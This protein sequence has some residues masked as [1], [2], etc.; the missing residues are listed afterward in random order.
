MRWNLL[1]DVRHNVIQSK[2]CVL[3]LHNGDYWV[4]RWDG[5]SFYDQWGARLNWLKREDIEAYLPVT[6]T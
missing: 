3:R 1:R 2:L 4:A 6:L 5:S